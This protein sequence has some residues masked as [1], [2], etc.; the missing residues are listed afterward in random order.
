M[1][2]TKDVSLINCL[3]TCSQ[4]KMGHWQ[5]T[6]KFFT[7]NMLSAEDVSLTNYLKDLR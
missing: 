7:L 6:C 1:L 3:K 5:T 4:Q 2:A